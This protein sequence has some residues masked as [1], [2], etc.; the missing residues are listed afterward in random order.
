MKKTLAFL[1]ALLMTLSLVGGALAA[2]ANLNPGGEKPICKEPV[3]LTIG[4]A[5]NTTVM[6]WATQGQT[7][8]LE[9]YGFELEFVTYPTAEFKTKID[10]EMMAG[11][12]N[13]PD[14]VLGNFN[15]DVLQTYAE[16]GLIYDLTEYYEAGMAHYVEIAQQEFNYDLLKYITTPEGKIYSFLYISDS[17]ENQFRSRIL[18]NKDWLDKL[19]LEIPRTTEEYRE[20]LK[21]FKEKDPNG[22]GLA[23]EVPFM[24]SRDRMDAHVINFF[25]SPFVY[26]ISEDNYLYLDGDT[27]KPAYAQDGWKDGVLY[28]RSLV[29]E[30]LVSPLTFTQDANQVNAFSAGSDVERLGSTSVQVSKVYTNLTTA[31]YEVQV[32]MLDSL[33]LPGGEQIAPYSPVTPTPSSFITTNCE[34]PEAAFRFLDLLCKE[35]F[36]IMTRFGIEGIDWVAPTAEEAAKFPFQKL[37]YEPFMREISIWGQPNGNWWANAGPA[38]RSARMLGGRVGSSG[39]N[40]VGSEAAARAHEFIHPE[41]AVG[42]ILYTPDEAATLNTLQTDLLTYAREQYTMFVTRQRDVEKEWDAYLSELEAIGLSEY[43]DMVQTAYDRMNGK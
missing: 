43:M 31:E 30:G 3:K 13:L 2:D 36:S 40:W 4:V 28:M 20:V 15:L 29:D 38:I 10:L 27:V 24:G 33:S 23:D 35:E 5:E 6:D 14:V 25:M 26:A 37:G 32:Y 17:L 19:N 12:Q 22:N 16:Y 9:E 21:A 41:L 7:K 34:N 8:L 39:S 1:V 18:I 42:Q 11:G